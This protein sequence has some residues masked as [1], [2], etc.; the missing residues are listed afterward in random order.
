MSIRTLTFALLATTAIVVPSIAQAQSQEP[1]A[2][3]PPATTAT[4]QMIDTSNTA[5]ARANPFDD[6]RDDG[7]EFAYGH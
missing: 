1:S 2:T 3:A 4:V 7:P 5:S 6:Q